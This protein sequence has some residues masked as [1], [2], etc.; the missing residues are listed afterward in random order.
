MNDNPPSIGASDTPVPEPAVRASLVRLSFDAAS[1]H[2]SAVLTPSADAVP[3]T[4][5]QLRAQLAAEGY[6]DFHASDDLLRPVVLAASKGQDG[7]HVIAEQRDARLELIVGSDRLSLLARSERAWGGRMLDEAFIWSRLRELG[8]PARCVLPD[9][10]AQLLTGADLTLELAHA[11]LPEAGRDSRF[12]PLVDACKD[13]ALQED[14][15]GRVDFYESHEFVVVDAGVPL[16]RR[17]PPTPG[18]MGIDVCGTVLSPE[19]GKVLPFGKEMVGARI[20]PGDPDL[21]VAEIKG[22]PVVMANCVA[23][24]PIL[25]LKNVGLATGNISFDGSV[26]IAGDVAPGL[27]VQA[28][29]DIVIRGM[30]EKARITA[31]RNLVIQGGVMG[32]DL[33]RDGDGELILRTRLR[34]GGDISAKFISLAEVVAGKTLRV[35]EYVMQ[36]HLSAGEGILLGQGGGRGSLIGGRARAGVSLV[37]NILGSDAYVF[38]EVRIG[39]ESFKRRWLDRLKQAYRQTRINL[40]QLQTLLTNPPAGLAPD[41]LSRIEVTMVAETERQ[42]RIRRIVERLLARQRNAGPGQIVIKRS[43]HANV[44]LAID[45]ISQL[46]E[47]DLGPRVLVRSGSALVVKP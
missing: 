45:G 40:Q 18:K 31:R 3:I 43:L 14:E 1:R 11:Q 16:M 42:E 27:S 6:G 26:E 35:R 8:V 10:I 25:R 36:C 20:S 13:V 46:N 23:V 21:L 30:V 17:M 44:S 15:Q 29:G 19:P 47:Q 2:V 41:K 7:C 28:T 4:L 39:R 34:A 38:T 9:A 37:A 22:H 33:G 24:D 12:E 32:D 5:E